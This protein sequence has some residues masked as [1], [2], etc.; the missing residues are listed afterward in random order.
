MAINTEQSKKTVGGVAREYT[1]AYPVIA[2]NSDNESV[3]N[4]L[5]EKFGGK[6]TKSGKFESYRWSL[7][8]N[9]AVDLALSMK[10]AVPYRE[11]AIAAFELWEHSDLEER[12]L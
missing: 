6:K 8:S 11:E 5:V 1:Y 2:F 12:L 3:I 9:D 4:G 7:K 10:G